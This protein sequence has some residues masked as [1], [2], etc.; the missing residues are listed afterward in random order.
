MCLNFFILYGI[1]SLRSF[2]DSVFFLPFSHMITSCV[3]Y[4]S[5]FWI[6]HFGQYFKE[7]S[8]S[9]RMENLEVQADG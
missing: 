4:D 3:V 9:S 5:D 7:L 1:S 6:S 8:S 2:P